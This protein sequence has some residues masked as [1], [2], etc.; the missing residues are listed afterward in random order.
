[1][2]RETMP[3]L[4][5]DIIFISYSRRDT[6]VMQRIVLF[7][8]DQ[9]FKVWVDNER[10]IPGTSIWEEEIEKAIKAASTVLVI[11]S[12]DSKNSEWVRREISLADQYR[13]HILPILV[14]GDEDTS[15]TLR[16]V[17]RQFVDLRQNEDAGLKSLHAALSQHVQE[18]QI[19]L[20]DSGEKSTEHGSVSPSQST[21]A[22][23]P[24]KVTDNAVSTKSSLST[25]MTAG[26]T[27]S[28]MIGG[29]LYSEYTTLIGG[30]AG[31]ALGGLVTSIVSQVGKPLSDQKTILRITLAWTIG[32]AIGWF[33]GDELTEAIGMA[34]GYTIIAGVGWASLTGF[35]SIRMNWMSTVWVISAWAIGGALGWSIGRYVQLNDVFDVATGWALGH[36][37]AWAI[38]G[39]VMSRQ[40]LKDRN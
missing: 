6:E 38:G 11:M 15:I 4:S 5:E 12:P 35:Q 13:K 26:L 8:R 9:G 1:M 31:G 18:L 23:E 25:W 34:I 14:H 7:L 33:I 24:A 10:L 17:T 27:I 28:G 21:I 39:F 36:A 19:Q 3:T 30:A 22:H 16:L 37:I 29:F 40:V 20:D 2:T 32:G